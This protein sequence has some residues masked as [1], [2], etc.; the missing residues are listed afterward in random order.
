MCYHLCSKL[1]LQ[2]WC[3]VHQVGWSI[4]RK[5]AAKLP[6]QVC[7]DKLISRKIKLAASVHAIWDIAATTQIAI[8]V[9]SRLALQICKLRANLTRQECKC[10]TSFQQV[11][12]EVTM[13]RICS[14]L[15]ASN[16]LQIIVKTEYEH[17]LRIELATYC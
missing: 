3:E 9:C 6:L 10:E 17:S 13:G 5:F 12:F 2:S 4:C 7:H 15:A 11:N 8:L 1:V 14:K 16:S